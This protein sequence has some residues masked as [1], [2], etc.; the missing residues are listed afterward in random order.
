[1]AAKGACKVIVTQNLCKKSNITV[2]GLTLH[3]HV[4]VLRFYR[5]ISLS[6]N[7]RSGLEKTIAYFRD[8]LT[9]T[10]EIIPTGPNAAQPHRQ[11]S[12][13]VDVKL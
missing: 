9:Q 1:M 5:I 10:G 11:G 13:E 6:L 12:E 2:I 3:A 7:C 8:E 4:E